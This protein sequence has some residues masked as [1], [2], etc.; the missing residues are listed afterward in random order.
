M[1]KRKGLFLLE[2]LLALLILASLAAAL[3]PLA[4]QAAKAEILASVRGKL[5]NQGLFAMDFMVEKIRNNRRSM[6]HGGVHGNRYDYRAPTGQ[7]TIGTYRLFED[8]EK[9]KVQLYNDVI[10]PITGDRG[11]SVEE[12]V[13]RHPEGG[14]LF[15]QADNGPV[16]IS[17]TLA[18]PIGRE[19]LDFETAVIPYADFYGKGKIYET[20]KSF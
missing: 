6:V 14:H 20:G 1:K 15:E 10:Q 12:Y 5:G 17:F 18:R 11:G 8:Q 3:F 2:A 19:S 7:G 13:F 4:G 9:L 16:T